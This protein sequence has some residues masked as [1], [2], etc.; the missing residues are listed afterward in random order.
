MKAILQIG[1]RGNVAVT[2]L[3][4]GRKIGRIVFDG[5]TYWKQST[6]EVG[7]ALVELPAGRHV[8]TFIA[9]GGINF[10]DLQFEKE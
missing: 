8:L 6:D 10:R 3:M 1:I 5:C 4:D 9:E 2:L 7:S